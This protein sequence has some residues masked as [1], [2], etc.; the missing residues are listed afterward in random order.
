MFG[1]GHPNN[2]QQ[3]DPVSKKSSESTSEVLEDERVLDRLEQVPVAVQEE[4]LDVDVFMRVLVR[5]VY[6]G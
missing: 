3:V 5:A 4:G 1:P 2:E 6:R